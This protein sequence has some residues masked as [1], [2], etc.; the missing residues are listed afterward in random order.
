LNQHPAIII[1]AAA[2]SAENPTPVFGRPMQPFHRGPATWAAYIILGFY[3]G[4]LAVITAAMPFVRAELNLSYT[5]TAIYLSAVAVGILTAG[6]SGDYL[7]RRFGRKRLFIGVAGLEALALVLLGLAR[8]PFLVL[9]A[10]YLLGLGGALTQVLVQIVLPDLHPARRAVVISESNLLAGIATA[11]TPLL[12]GGIRAGL[13]DWRPAPLLWALLI[14][15]WIFAFRRAQFPAG[16]PAEKQA[17]APRLPAVFS[18]ILPAVFLMVAAEWGVAFWTPDFLHRV[19][20]YPVVQ[21]STLLSVYFGAIV[22]G[23]F[24]GSLLSRRF[25]DRAILFAALLTAIL[26]LPLYWLMHW[27]WARL[28]GLFIL[29]LGIGNHYP[30]VFSFAMSQA[31][32]AAESASSRMTLMAGAAIF[33]APLLLGSLADRIGIFPSLGLVGLMLLAALGAVWSA[34]R[35]STCR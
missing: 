34:A 22:V 28:G 20:G 33:S 12:V 1:N 11:L 10:A 15:A 30:M 29:G 8:L 19:A 25:S 21:A 7:V 5:A 6:I 24:G 13:Q 17:R 3:A 18:A 2:I 31:G 32:A 27:P 23:R 14:A 16:L 4:S 9:A 35:A 26:G